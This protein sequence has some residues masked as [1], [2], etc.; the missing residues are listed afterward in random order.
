MTADELRQKY[1]GWE[2][3]QDPDPEHKACR[4]TGEIVTSRTSAPC[5]CAVSSEPHSESKR[6]FMREIGKAAKRIRER[7]FPDQTRNGR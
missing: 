4:G 3:R 6:E 1:P 2:I 5:F 7:D